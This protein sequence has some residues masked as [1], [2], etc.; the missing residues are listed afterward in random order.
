MYYYLRTYI[1][2][3]SHKYSYTVGTLLRKGALS[4]D[5]IACSK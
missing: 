1:H 4:G 3:D 2:K 5:V